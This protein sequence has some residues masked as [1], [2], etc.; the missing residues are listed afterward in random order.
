VPT[1]LALVLGAAVSDASKD[2]AAVLARKTLA[3]E[4]GIAESSI[5]VQSVAAAEWP[6]ASL[7][8]P[9]KGMQYAQVITHGHRVALEAGGRAYDVHVSGSEA[10]VCDAAKKGGEHLAAAARLS[11]LARRDLASRLGV[12][13]EKVKTILLRPRTWPDASLGCPK[14]DMSYA[15]METKGFVIELEAGGKKYRYHS[16]MQRLVPCDQ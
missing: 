14:P 8:C 9:R 5:R 11:E 10:V 16:D 1:L 15:Q 3:A 12:P 13:A 2:P 6:D 7:G 4:L